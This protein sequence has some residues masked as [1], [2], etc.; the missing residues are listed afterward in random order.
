MASKNRSMNSDSKAVIEE[1]DTK[2]QNLVSEMECVEPLRSAVTHTL[3]PAGKRIRPRVSLAL[4]EDLGGE[5]HQLVPALCALEMVHNASLIHDDLPEMDNDDFR[6]G[7]P[8]C[9]K[10]FGSPTALLAGDFMVPQALLWLTQTEFGAEQKL[11]MI[12]LLSKGYSD[13][14]SGQQLDILPEKDRGPL[15][16]IHELKTGSLFR[17]ACAFGAIGAHIPEP[18]IHVCGELGTKIGIGF[19][20]ADDFI[21]RFGK[22]EERG[23]PEGSDARNNKVTFFSESTPAEGLSELARNEEEIKNKFEEISRELLVRRGWG[24]EFLNTRQIVEA[25]FSRVRRK[26]L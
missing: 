1:I 6:R 12:E 25:I 3:F 20:I 24:S 7:R 10:A 13:V 15:S 23:R 14:C 22:E 11:L 8:T 4:C 26:S 2:L 17:V 19:Q 5:T 18:L 21:D 9:H 16:R